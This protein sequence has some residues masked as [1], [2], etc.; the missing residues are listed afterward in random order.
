MPTL[1][2]LKQEDQNFKV[3]L[4]QPGLHETPTLSSVFIV[5]RYYLLNRNLQSPSLE[6]ILF[7]SYS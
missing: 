4:G 5:K 3:I 1:G 2:R 6:L 7:A